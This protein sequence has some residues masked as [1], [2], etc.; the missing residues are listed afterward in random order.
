MFGL[1]L[2]LLVLA[3]C[4]PKTGPWENP[5]VDTL[6][7]GRIFVSNTKR[8]ATGG[9]RLIEDLR[10]GVVEGGGPTQFS[11]IAHVVSD[12]RRRVFVVDYGSQEIRIFDG[13]GRHLRSIGGP[14]QGPGE[15]TGLSGISL[16]PGGEILAWD[17]RMRRYTIFD[18]TGTFLRT[19]ERKVRGNAYPWRGRFDPEGRLIDFGVSNPGGPG[20]QRSEISLAFPIRVV[21]DSEVLDTGAVLVSRTINSK[22][23][24]TAIPFTP[25]LTYDLDDKGGFWIAHTA[26]YLIHMRTFAGDTTV[27]F[28]LDAEAPVVSDSERDSLLGRRGTGPSSRFGPEDIPDRKPIL[29]RVISNGADLVLVFPEPGVGGP[30]QNLDVF[31]TKGVFLDR[32]QVPVPVAYPIPAPFAR[33]RDLLFVTTDEFDVQHVVRYRLVGEMIPGQG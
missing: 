18:S 17:P 31:S 30:G 5:V 20:N 8:Q 25:K 4:G 2:V 15:F 1:G 22:S 33:D 21:F 3:G 32:V 24:T 10:L 16:E 23:G 14:G 28:S 29:R 19:E 12:D 11:E 6:E 26:E 27:S 13:Q 7:S 9:L